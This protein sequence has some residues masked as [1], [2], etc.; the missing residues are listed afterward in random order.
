MGQP[1]AD[2]AQDGPATT[3]SEQVPSPRIAL[4][5][6]DDVA[7]SLGR[8]GFIGSRVAHLADAEVDVLSLD[9]APLA[10]V[11]SQLHDPSTRLIVVSL[12]TDFVGETWRHRDDGTLVHPPPGYRDHWAAEDLASLEGDHELLPPASVDEIERDLRRLAEHAVAMGAELLVLNVS[13][14]TPEEKV[15]SFVAGAEPLAIRATKIDLMLDRL[16]PELNFS[17]VDVDRIV[18]E[19]GA[20]AHVTAS[21]RYTD[22]ACEAIAEEA[23]AT[24]AELPALN[25]LF[26]SDVMRL[27][28]PRYDKRTVHGTIVEWHRQAPGNVVRGEALFDVRFDNLHY[29]LEEPKRAKSHRAL[30]VSVLAAHDGHLREIL[31]PAGS[32]VEVG[33]AVAVMTNDEHTPADA[34]DAVAAFPVGVKV[35]TR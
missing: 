14:V 3:P 16:A 28:V 34:A 26:G 20:G 7:R 2:A 6:A 21:G 1:S 15:T 18:A 27:V 29:R 33:T 35:A 30:L 9:A 17:V 4:V 12:A 32:P 11:V 23:M 8:K 5:C 31:C 24:I 22:E 25:E 10:L 13:T 19:L